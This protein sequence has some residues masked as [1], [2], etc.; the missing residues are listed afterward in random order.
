MPAPSL[1]VATF[2]LHAGV[3]GWGRPFDIEKAVGSLDA[4]VIVLQEVWKP[5]ATPSTA[6][7]VASALGYEVFEQALA[8]GRRA[9]PHPQADHRW[10]RAFDW[11]GNSHAIYLDSE[12]TL[13]PAVVRSTRFAQAETG[14][15]GIA[16]ITRLPVLSHKVID[17]GMPPRDRTQRAA[18]VVR[19][20]VEG[21]P[22]TVAG[23]HMTHLTYGSPKYF[24]RM[25]RTLTD[26]TG[27][28]P[29]VLAGDMN[30]WGP[31]TTM[32]LRGWRRAVTGRT[33]P[34][35]RPHSQIDHIFVKGPLAVTDGSVM[36]AGG[37]DHRAIRARLSLT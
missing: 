17:L 18:L 8:T 9:G 31:P 37:S 6:Q 14:S 16:V 10:M 13:P 23:T 11:R 26:L 29:A 35:W 36:P 25:N 15:W 20:D 19:V 1:V 12:R 28:E 4:D 3:D 21:R 33:W 27:D 32:L 2:N 5:P 24:V 7:S 22:V 30:L 34:S